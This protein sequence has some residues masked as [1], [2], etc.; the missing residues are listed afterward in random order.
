MT[1]DELTHQVPVTA[2]VAAGRTVRRVPGFRGVDTACSGDIG[3]SHGQWCCPPSYLRGAKAEVRRR[4]V[5]AGFRAATRARSMV[6]KKTS[7]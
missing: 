6:R 7:G 2:S 3:T 1:E 5:S 4:K